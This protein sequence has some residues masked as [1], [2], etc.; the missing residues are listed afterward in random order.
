[1]WFLGVSDPLFFVE[2]PL[3]PPL[4]PFASLTDP[5]QAAPPRGDLIGNWCVLIS[6]CLPRIQI[7]PKF[8]QEIANGEGVRLRTPRGPRS[9]KFGGPATPRHL[10]LSVFR[11]NS[12]FIS[13]TKIQ[14]ASG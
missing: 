5:L 2:P 6:K 1:V 8:H 13:I 10:F 9:G 4:E 3:E 14:E 12:R 7:F 11:G